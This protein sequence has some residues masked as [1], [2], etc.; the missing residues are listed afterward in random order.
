MGM[1]TRTH[2]TQR[3]DMGDDAAH[4]IIEHPAALKIS[5]L[6]RRLIER[7]TCGPSWCTSYR[8]RSRS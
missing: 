6:Q 5:R 3:L 2:F 7:P 4:N 1:K 8:P